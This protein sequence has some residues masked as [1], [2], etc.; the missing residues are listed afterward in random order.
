MTKIKI[1]GLMRQEDILAVN[2][3]YFLALLIRLS[4]VSNFYVQMDDYLAYF[5]K[6]APIYTVLCIV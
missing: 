3:A 4:I 5:I 1:C 2:A 6:F